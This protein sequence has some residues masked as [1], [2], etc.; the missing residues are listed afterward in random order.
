MKIKPEW[1]IRFR[2]EA[3]NH[4]Q[5][6]QQIMS[7]WE[8]QPP[9]EIEIPRKLRQLF[10]KAHSIKGTAS[11]M[12][13]TAITQVAFELET[14]WGEVLLDPTHYDTS[15][16]ELARDRVTQL[17]RLVEAIQPPLNQAS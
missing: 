4:L 7:D 13:L 16:K 2:Q 6:A 8:A 5:E 9:E 17:T 3:T 1:L 12:N 15:Q 10:I 14:L 11:M